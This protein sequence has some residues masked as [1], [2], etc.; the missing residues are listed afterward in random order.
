[1]NLLERISNINQGL[2][3]KRAPEKLSYRYKGK[4]VTSTIFTAQGK[5]IAKTKIMSPE[6][7]IEKAWDTEAGDKETLRKYVKNDIEAVLA[8][9]EPMGGKK[10]KKQT[11]NRPARSS[12]PLPVWE[13]L[14]IEIRR[15]APWLTTTFGMGKADDIRRNLKDWVKV[16]KNQHPD[17]TDIYQAAT[18]RAG[19]KIF[20]MFQFTKEDPGPNSAIAL[21]DIHADELGLE[22]GKTILWQILLDFTK[23]HNLGDWESG[24][25]SSRKKY[26]TNR[27]FRG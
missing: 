18:F 13:I 17:R 12:G 19:N 1:M 21:E 14:Q 15:M 3:E 16:M 26:Y 4:N 10:K 9:K 25:Q 27:E 23:H 6:G 22:G 5:W 11:Q 7:G 2:T 8:G 24:R 20:L